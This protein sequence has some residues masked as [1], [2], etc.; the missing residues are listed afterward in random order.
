MPSV[1]KGLRG[2]KT[3]QTFY[4]EASFSLI[5]R[6]RGHFGCR[7]IAGITSLK[8]E[9]LHILGLANKLAS[10]CKCY[11][12]VSHIPGPQMCVCGVHVF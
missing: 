10:W 6:N 7:D 11:Y 4:S 3:F 2:L 8:M 9:I 1:P 5:I 12:P